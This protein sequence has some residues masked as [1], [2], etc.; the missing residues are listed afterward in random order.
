MQHVCVCVGFNGIVGMHVVMLHGVMLC[1]NVFEAKLPSANLPQSLKH[2]SSPRLPDS[3][4][5]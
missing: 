3:H 5:P 2:F 1:L 4:L